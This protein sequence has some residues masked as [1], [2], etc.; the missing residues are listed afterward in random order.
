MLVQGGIAGLLSGRSGSV[1]FA[2]NRGG[3]YA[4]DFTSPTDPGTARQLLLRSALGS[5]NE[6][7]RNLSATDRTVWENYGKTVTKRN[8]FGESKHVTGRAHF[9][10]WFLAFTG[11]LDFEPTSFPLPTDLITPARPIIKINQILVN[12]PGNLFIFTSFTQL[13]P[14]GDVSPPDQIIFY[15]SPP[16]PLVRNFWK[17]N[18]P[19][20]DSIGFSSETI[21]PHTANWVI[22]GGWDQAGGQKIF[23]KFRFIRRDGRISSF[24][25]A[26]GI[27]VSV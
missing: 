18:F 6:E 15:G 22:T 21:N 20:H 8:R 17:Q 27:S 9:V 11:G 12:A 3:A 4:R 16:L 7:W 13:D 23:M 26:D 10:A 2:R 14:W 19:S 24:T 25:Y 5:A 1:V